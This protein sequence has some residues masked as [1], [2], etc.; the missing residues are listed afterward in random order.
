MRRPLAEIEWQPGQVWRAELLDADG[1]PLDDIL[2][3]VHVPPPEWELR[4][5]LH[6]NPWLVRRCAEL[7][8][9][10][11]FSA[12]AEEQTTLWPTTDAIEA[13][14]WALLPRMLTL[15]GARWLLGQVQR[16]RTAVSALL[17]SESPEAVARSRAEIAGRADIVNWFARPLRIV[18]A[19][20]PNVGKSTLANA[21]ADRPVSLVSATPGTTRDWVEVPA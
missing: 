17:E 18:L 8:G 16:L 12:T 3:S 7:L 9:A 11:G 10:C 6:A 21:L 13:E 19:G 14:A 5:H 1:A 15:R 4:L 20:P 2:V